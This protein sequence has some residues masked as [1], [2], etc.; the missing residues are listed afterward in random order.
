MSG[1]PRSSLQ[2]TARF[3][4][5]A[6]RDGQASAKSDADSVSTSKSQRFV[7]SPLRP[8]STSPDC[9]SSAIAAD[10]VSKMRT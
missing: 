6:C 2:A 8:N 10:G 5:S 3:F 7:C 9:T 1:R 4:A